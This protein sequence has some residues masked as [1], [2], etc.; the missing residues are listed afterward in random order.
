[1]A[2]LIMNKSEIEDYNL[3]KHDRSSI[4]ISINSINSPEPFILKTTFNNIKRILN[5]SFN[6]TELISDIDGAVSQ[7]QAD[8]I[9]DFVIDWVADVDDLIVQCEEGRS[10]S[11]GVAKAIMEVLEI[12]DGN[13]DTER[14]H[15][16]NELCYRLVK[17]G[18]E[19]YD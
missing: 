6:D 5:V 2:I 14:K 1:M 4:V 9:A 8:K 3:Q 12:N 13:L 7:E 17:Q 11:A 19:K 18:F 16:P 10:R 15:S